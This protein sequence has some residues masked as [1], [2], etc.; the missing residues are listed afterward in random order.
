M[1]PPTSAPRHRGC[2]YRIG[3]PTIQC[4]NRFGRIEIVSAR[5]RHPKR[6]CQLRPTGA[7][8]G[9][10]TVQPG[11][12]LVTPAGSRT[13]RFGSVR[14]ANPAE[15]PMAQ[16]PSTQRRP[17]SAAAALDI[18]CPSQPIRHAIGAPRE[19]PFAAD[20]SLMRAAVNSWCG[21][22]SDHN[23]ALDVGA[24][25]DTTTR[26]LCAPTCQPGRPGPNGDGARLNSRA[27]HNNAS[28]SSFG[29]APRI[30]ATFLV[31]RSMVSRSYPTRSRTAGCVSGKY[32]STL[33]FPGLYIG[34]PPPAFFDELDHFSNQFRWPPR[35]LAVV[36]PAAPRHVL[37]EQGDPAWARSSRQTPSR[38]ARSNS[39]SSMSVLDIVHS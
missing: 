33:P 10:P 32:P 28:S 31:R 36:A 35:S 16:R 11:G 14:R 19:L 20:T 39:G 5:Q 18:L 21:K 29:W 6:Q 25:S 30:A 22:A 7:W 23:T 1:S 4:G 26:W 27:A 24:A 38:S 15:P 37:T 9:V 2:I 8:R 17:A 34:R 12:R 13:D 3:D